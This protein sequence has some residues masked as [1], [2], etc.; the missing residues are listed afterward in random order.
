MYV[1]FWQLE[2]GWLQFVKYVLYMIIGSALIG[3]AHQSPSAFT[4]YIIGGFYDFKPISI[5]KKL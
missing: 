5:S 3:S 1:S 2:P 4:K